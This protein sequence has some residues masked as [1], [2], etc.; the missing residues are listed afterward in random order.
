M[1][2]LHGVSPRDRWLCVLPGCQ[3]NVNVNVNGRRPV[4]QIH[5]R[6]PT[7]KPQSVARSQVDGASQLFDRLRDCADLRSPVPQ[8][9]TGNHV[10]HG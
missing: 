5:D 6:P 10:G 7:E 3:M 1:S 8:F 4:D 9:R 2:A